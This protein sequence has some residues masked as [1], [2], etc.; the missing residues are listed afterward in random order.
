[1][2]EEVHDLTPAGRIRRPSYSLVC[3]WVKDS[4]D[5]IDENLIKKS[6]KCCG[7]SVKTDGTEDDLIFDYEGLESPDDHMF[8]DDN[9][10]DDGDNEYEDVNPW[11][12]GMN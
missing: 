9:G 5:D 7:V 2:M 1:M 6:F 8:D 4:W 12:V 3:S 11:D 10:D